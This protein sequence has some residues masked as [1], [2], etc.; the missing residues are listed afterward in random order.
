MISQR[1]GDGVKWTGYERGILQ[2][3]RLDGLTCLLFWFASCWNECGYKWSQE[4]HL[5]G[6]FTHVFGILLER[7]MRI[8]HNHAVFCCARNPASVVI[9]NPKCPTSWRKASQ[10]SVPGGWDFW[11]WYSTVV[12]LAVEELQRS[13]EWVIAISRKSSFRSEFL[14]HDEE[15]SLLMSVTL[16][17]GLF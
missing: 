4:D 13:C 11:D 15:N 17:R 9:V 8:K 7:Q 6:L 2:R 16:H 14:D 12:H 3:K 10:Q 5:P 1:I